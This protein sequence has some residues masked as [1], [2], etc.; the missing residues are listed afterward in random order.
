MPTKSFDI[1][2][3]F[4]PTNY[5][6]RMHLSLPTSQNA[7]NS[8]GGFWAIRTLSVTFSGPTKRTFRLMVLSIR[9]TVV[10]GPMSSRQLVSQ[11]LSIHQSCVCGWV[12]LRILDC[13]HSSSRIQWL[14]I[15]IFKSPGTRASS[16]PTKTN[17]V[18]L[19]FHARRCLT[20]LRNQSPELSREHIRWSC[21][22]SRVRQILAP[23]FTRFEPSWLLVLGMDEG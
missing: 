8:L 13:S 12:S 7:V 11:N 1:T 19:H 2:W 3:D 4:T 18:I 9:T 21:D 17:V 16:T 20:P 14:L 22:K 5:R 23:T 15:L 6:W 10:S